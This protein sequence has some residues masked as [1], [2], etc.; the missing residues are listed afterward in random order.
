MN[1]SHPHT[2]VVLVGIFIL[3]HA[4]GIYL[5]LQAP[6]TF[7]TDFAEEDGI[8]EYLTAVLLFG[9]SMALLAQA[10]QW[11][12]FGGLKRFGLLTAFYALLF[13]F[14]A[15]EEVSWGQRIF[16]WESTEYFLENNH[17]GET[18][19]HNL[20]LGEVN[21]TKTLFGWV[22]TTAVLLYLLV[23][24][25]LYGRARRVDRFVQVMAVP[26]PRLQH[27]LMA[28]FATGL[29]AFVDVQRQFEL[30]ELAFSIITLA[31]F[32]HPR[33]GD[34]YFNDRATDLIP[35]PAA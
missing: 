5:M 32:L 23:L 26:V 29:M 10:I 21:L 12:S 4:V 3:F 28:L 27:A 24:P 8:V 13:F 7:A 20:M 22:L 16:G 2:D 31:I 17:Q 1:R 11:Y 34:M 25:A 30:Y 35:A 18:N 15:G 19:L 33:N 14:A 6:E 9:G